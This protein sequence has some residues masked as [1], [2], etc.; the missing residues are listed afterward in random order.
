L[1]NNEISAHGFSDVSFGKIKGL[2]ISVSK[3]AAGEFEK[4]VNILPVLELLSVVVSDFDRCMKKRLK[5]YFPG[6]KICS[7]CGWKTNKLSVS[8][9]CRMRC[10]KQ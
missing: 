4:M 8:K 5:Y 10:F 3:Y 7:Q 1:H 6:E 2:P 9:V